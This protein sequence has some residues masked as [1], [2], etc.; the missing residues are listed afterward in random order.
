MDHV[1]GYHG[2]SDRD[3]LKVVTESEWSMFILI[4]II[5]YVYDNTF[6]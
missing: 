6:S 1:D 5:G 4:I 3:F 2:W